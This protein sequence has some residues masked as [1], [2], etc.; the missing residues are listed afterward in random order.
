MLFLQSFATLPVHQTKNTYSAGDKCQYIRE[1]ASVARA[2]VAE[3]GRGKKPKRRGRSPT[4]KGTERKGTSLLLCG[5]RAS[6]TVEEGRGYLMPNLARSRA[7][8]SYDE[9]FR[10]YEVSLMDRSR[11]KLPL[12]VPSTRKRKSVELATD[13]K[14]CKRGRSPS[15]ALSQHASE[16]YAW[17]VRSPSQAGRSLARRRQVTARLTVNCCS[18]LDLAGSSC[19]RDA[20]CTVE[21]F[22]LETYVAASPRSGLAAGAL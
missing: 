18:C 13:A 2:P 5:P 1:D 9:Q 3:T 16:T 8:F 22:S 19:V 4:H 7:H 14:K 10:T 15:S 17:P 6:T 12:G 20:G 21:K 11:Y